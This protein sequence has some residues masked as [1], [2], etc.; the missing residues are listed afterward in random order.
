MSKSSVFIQNTR[1]NER[2]QNT[3]GKKLNKNHINDAV[4]TQVDD[5]LMIKGLNV[6]EYIY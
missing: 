3:L 5:K 4:K 1:K 6:K 2:N